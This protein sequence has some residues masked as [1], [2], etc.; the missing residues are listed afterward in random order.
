ME[1]PAM[2]AILNPHDH[3]FKETFARPEIAR[4]F[5]TN[6]LPKPTLARLN[7]ATLNLQKDTFIGPNL[8]EHFSGMLYQVETWKRVR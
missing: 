5:S 1:S 3:Y 8:R 4:E 7:L 2:S 6:F